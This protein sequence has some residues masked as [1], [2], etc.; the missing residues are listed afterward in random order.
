MSFTS[1]R[2]NWV[3]RLPKATPTS[4]A[5]SF[6]LRYLYFGTA[7]IETDLPIR[8]LLILTSNPWFSLILK[9]P[10]LANRLFIPWQRRHRYP[11]PN[12]Q[13]RPRHWFIRSLGRFNLLSFLRCRHSTIR[14][15]QV[16]HRHS[17]TNSIR[18]NPSRYSLWLRT[19]GG[20][21]RGRYRLH[22]WLYE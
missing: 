11:R 15:F 19:S 12:I 7:S 2:V 14:S 8:T 1:G 17:I 5:C 20:C 16:F 9:H 10:L 4:D 3:G 21:R 13:R 22:G 6:V 18:R